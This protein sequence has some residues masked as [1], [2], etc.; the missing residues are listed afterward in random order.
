[1]EP[2][3]LFPRSKRPTTGPCPEPDVP[4]S[5]KNIL[6]SAYSNENVVL[7]CDLSHV[8]YM[9]GPSHLPY[10]IFVI[11]SGV[12]FDGEELHYLERGST[13]EGKG[14]EEEDDDDD[15]DD[16]GDDNDSDSDDDDEED[17]GDGGEENGITALHFLYRHADVKANQ[18][19]GEEAGF[20]YFI[21]I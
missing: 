6:P 11:F 21:L 3:A 9:F 4:G 18:T 7:I 13:D 8:C 19:C 16:D 20:N 5:S 14:G 2:K 12:I 1:M 17:E 15:N 10:S